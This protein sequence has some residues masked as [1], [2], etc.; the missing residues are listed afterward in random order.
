M[1][2]WDWV[3]FI[4]RVYGVLEG[5]KTLVIY[6]IWWY[7]GYLLLLKV[8]WDKVV[9]VFICYGDDGNY[10]DDGVEWLFMIVL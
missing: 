1:G 5:Y 10:L 9:V 4:W 3:V 6:G 8:V 2:F 7:Y